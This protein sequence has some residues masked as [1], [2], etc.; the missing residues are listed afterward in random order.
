M[1][2]LFEEPHQTFVLDQRTCDINVGGN[3]SGVQSRKEESNGI[4]SSDEHAI[5]LNVVSAQCKS[6]LAMLS[7]PLWGATSRKDR[8][9]GASLL[10]EARHCVDIIRSHPSS[11][12]HSLEY[13]RILRGQVTGASS[14]KEDA[15]LALLQK[16]SRPLTACRIFISSTFT[17]T[18]NER[19]EFLVDG[20]PFLRHVASNLGLQFVPV[21]MRWGKSLALVF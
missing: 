19:D 6:D 15:D 18:Q 4:N 21:E 1:R 10:A 5:E 13:E 9:C 12:I 11:T 7:P 2:R 20:V 3:T 17:D 14:S 8:K 16:I